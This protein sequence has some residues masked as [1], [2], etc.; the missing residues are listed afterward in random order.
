MNSANIVTPLTG[1]R[2][3]A[4]FHRDGEGSSSVV[5]AIL[6]EE[7]FGRLCRRGFGFLEVDTTLTLSRRSARTLFAFGA[8][9][10]V[11]LPLIVTRPRNLGVL[12]AL[13]NTPQET[14]AARLRAAGWEKAACA[15]TLRQSARTVE[16]L[17]GREQMLARPRGSP[18]M[19]KGGGGH[20]PRH[21]GRRGRLPV[22]RPQASRRAGR[23][24]KWRRWKGKSMGPWRSSEPLSRFFSSLVYV[25]GGDDVV[26]SFLL[27]CLLFGGSGEKETL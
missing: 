7:V 18:S 1:A 15:H 2:A 16:A 26:F 20:H 21:G 25:S 19:Q 9:S 4:R 14:T 6:G 17:M 5:A 24:S 23:R 3:R 11:T 12:S 13:R 8:V 27:L 10:G 22:W